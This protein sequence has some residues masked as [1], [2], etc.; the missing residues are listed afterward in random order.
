MAQKKYIED[1]NIKLPGNITKSTSCA[2]CKLKAEKLEI[3]D[4]DPS[5][6]MNKPLHTDNI[7][8]LYIDKKEI[9]TL[10]KAEKVKTRKKKIDKTPKIKKKGNNFYNCVNIIMRI[11]TGETEYLEK[12]TKI[13]M[14]LFKNGSIQMSGCKSTADINIALSKLITILETEET[15]IISVINFKIDN[16]LANYKI[17]IEINRNKLFELLQMKKIQASYEP[18]IRACVVVKYTPHQENEQKNQITIS[19]FK[20]G[21]VLIAGARSDLHLVEAYKYLNDIILIH[22]DEIMSTEIANDEE[23]ILH[24]YKEVMKG[25]KVGLIKLD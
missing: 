1:K 2:S 3:F 14:K 5:I 13:N 24:L 6:I 19:I 12:E 22:Q 11:S 16:I 25:V 17:N 20:L 21:N 8:S 7:I 10:L 4:I 15:G 9:K 18:C 23:L